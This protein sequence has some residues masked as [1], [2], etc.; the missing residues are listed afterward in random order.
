MGTECPVLIHY[1]YWRTVTVAQDL[2][3]ER[4]YVLCISLNLF[5]CVIWNTDT[6]EF[7]W[8]KLFLLIFRSGRLE[9]PAWDTLYTHC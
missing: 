2:L 1:A 3:T 6:V 5:P 8:T 7:E 4:N 9:K